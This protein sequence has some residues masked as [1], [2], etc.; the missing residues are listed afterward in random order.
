MIE[1]ACASASGIGRR[2]G[3][4]GDGDGHQHVDPATP[5]RRELGRGGD[6]LAVVLAAADMHEHGVV[7]GLVVDDRLGDRHDVGRHEIEPLAAAEDDVDHHP[8]HEPGAAGGGDA[9]IEHAD[10]Q[11]R[12]RG[13]RKPRDRQRREVVAAIRALPGLRYGRWRSGRRRTAAAGPGAPSR[14]TASPR[15]RR[16][17]Q[18]VRLAG[19]SATQARAENV[20]QK[21]A[22]VYGSPHIDNSARLCHAASTVAMK[23]ALGH[24]ASTCSYADWIGADLIVF[25][26]SN[27]PNNQPVTTKYVFNA[28][29]QGT[30]VAVVNPCGSRGWSATGSRQSPRAPSSERS[31]LITGSR[32]TPAGTWHSWSERSKRWWRGTRS[33]DLRGGAHDRLPGGGRC[34]RRGGVDGHRD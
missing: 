14:R 6:Q 22:R 15:R 30:K 19:S 20:A 11:Q 21:A 34:R 2:S 25:F 8:E 23:Q 12:E 13:A 7:L 3:T 4:R 31:W 1:S 24:G 29:K 5:D 10:D 18:E 32:C 16:S 27:T 33:T 17:R 26:G 9:E 28:R